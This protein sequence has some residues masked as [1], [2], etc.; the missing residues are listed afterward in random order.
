MPDSSS[1]GKESDMQETT[2]PTASPEAEFLAGAL[3]ASHLGNAPE[4]SETNSES[5]SSSSS[6]G[7]GGETDTKPCLKCV[8]Q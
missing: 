6:D 2:S 5:S 4:F 7:A 1:G 8:G 3:S